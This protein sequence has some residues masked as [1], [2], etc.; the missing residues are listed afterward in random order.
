MRTGCRFFGV[1]LVSLL[2]GAVACG[3]GDSTGPKGSSVTGISGDNQSGPTGGQLPIPLGFT[4]LRSN[5]QP[6]SGVVVSWSVPTGQATLTQSLDT[7]DTNGATGTGVTLG[8]QEGQ[9]V[10]RATVPGISAPVDFHL[11]VLN[12]CRFTIQP[13]VPGTVTGTLTNLDCNFLGE[14]YFYDF[15]DLFP[16][17]QQSLATSMSSTAFDAFLE[18]FEVRNDSIYSFAGNNDASQA[19]TNATVNTIAQAGHYRIG[20]STNFSAATGDYTLTIAARDP[21]LG[22]CGDAVYVTRGVNITENIATTDCADT[23][24][25]GIFYSD[26][27]GIV[28]FQGTVLT[29]SQHSTTI[30]PFLTLFQLTNSGV[31]GVASNDDS[32]ATNTDAFIQYSVPQNA[33]YVIVPGTSSAAETGAYTLTI[34]PSFTASAPISPSLPRARAVPHFLRQGPWRPL[35]VHAR[36]LAKL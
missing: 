29:I 10:V 19:T 9:V 7:S 14:G 25:G 36:P 35:T 21:T 13:Q 5:G 8:A 28:A 11:T 32:S 16:G 33:L 12:A 34:S 27:A 4:V 22:Q 6:A 18:L 3:G 30:N 15:Y 23:T 31:V 17:A 20:A 24:P 1:A 26:E 2:G